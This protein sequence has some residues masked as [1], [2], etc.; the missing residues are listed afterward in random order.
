MTKAM[1]KN[2]TGKNTETAASA[3]TPIIWPSIDAVATVPNS[4]CRMLL[5]II[6]ARKTQECLP[7]R[8]FS[9]RCLFPLKT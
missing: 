7:E 6:G 8:E 5:S 4:D 2:I 9:T 1:K 3:S